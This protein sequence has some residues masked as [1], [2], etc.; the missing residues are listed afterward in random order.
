MT[1]PDPTP[2]TLTIPDITGLDTMAAAFAYAKH[3]WHIG[4]VRPGTKHPGSILGR[5]WQSQTTRDPQV[6][7][8]YWMT[9]TDAGIFLHVGRSGAIVIDVDTPANLPDVLT[10]ALTEHPAPFQRT[11]RNDAARRHYIYRQPHGRTLGNGLGQLPHGWGDLRGSNGVIIVAPTPHPD[12]DPDGHYTWGRTGTIPELPTTI[13]DLLTD[14]T[15][16]VDVAS[17]ATIRDF[18]TLHNQGTDHGKARAM[19]ATY[20]K[21]IT[22]GDSR[23]QRAISILTGMLKEAAAGYYPAGHAE[24][25]L[26]TVFLDAVATPGHGQQGTART[27]HQA[28]EE[29]RG[30]LAWAIAQASH[31]NP[32]T[33]IERAEDHGPRDL[34]SLIDTRPTPTAAPVEH[35]VPAPVDDTTDPAPVELEAPTSLDRLLDPTTTTPTADTPTPSW[36]PLDLTRILDGTYTPPTPTIMTRTDGH[37]LFYPGKVHTVYGESESGKS[38]IAQHATVETLHTDGRVLYIDFESDAPDVTGRLTALGATTTQLLSTRFAYVRPEASPTTFHEAPDFQQLLNQPW[39]LAIL[40][41]VTEALGLSGRSTM[42]NDE[43]T[44]WMRDIPRRIARATGA[45]IILVDHVVKSAEGRGRFPIGGQAKMAA[46]DG[47][48]Y[49]VE[50]ISALGRGLDGSLTVRVAKDRPGQ[51]RAHAGDWRKT[52]RTQEA[53]RVRV[54]STAEDGTTRVTVQPPE[55]GEIHARDNDTPFRPTR[56][57]E[58]IS[59]ILETMREPISRR[60]LYK[61]YRDTGASAK[62]TTVAEATNLL[63]EGGYATETE[64][65]RNARMFRSAAVYRSANDALSEDYRGDLGSFSTTASDRLPTVSDRLPGDGADRLPTTVSHR[66]PFTGDGDGRDGAQPTLNTTTVSHL[67]K[68]TGEIHTGSNPQ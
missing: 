16:P 20:K 52:D 30:I 57:M 24:A 60:A 7:A 18:I 3:G 65:P 61:A 58:K 17:D 56:V 32:T 8:D 28:L 23:H 51:V 53:A 34:A 22:A 59:R 40:D 64:G 68:S 47:T 54:D 35:D 11:R 39:N 66:P 45:A 42:D 43:I 25:E 15:R 48:G 13:S 21:A 2:G 9:H 33:T 10:D 1:S 6:I 63:I 41:G 55:F 14:T 27:G 44:A 26:R 5:Q 49:L 29:W 62:E 37:A 19:I 4:P 36:R 67:N 38:W 46:I 31:A 12:P 50:P